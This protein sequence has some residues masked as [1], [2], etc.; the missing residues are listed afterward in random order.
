MDRRKEILQHIGTGKR[1]IEVAP[2]HNPLVP[3]GGD[4]EVVV[5][6]VFDRPTLL[7]RA[8]MDPAI[9]RASIPN[10][11]EVD[12]VGSACDIAELA[13][14][15]FGTD[16][17][18]DFVVSS[19]NVEHLPD[20]IRFLRGCE[21]LLAP[22]GILA[23]AVPDKRACFDFFRPH[24]GLGDLLQAFHERRERPTYAQTFGQLA[25][26][27]GLH[28][29]GTVTG[30]FSIN[31]DI[32][33]I[34]LQGDV[35]QA[36]AWWRERIDTDDTQYHD[37]HCWTFT[38][39]SL[40]L[41]LTEL[42]LLG[43]I[44]FEILEVTEPSGCEFFVHLR[45]RPVNSPAQQGLAERREWLLKR[46]VDEL[47]NSAGLETTATKHEGTVRRVA[48]PDPTYLRAMRGIRRRIRGRLGI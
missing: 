21:A 46:M 13:T 35:V 3:A 42:I 36:Y 5:L 27:A 43:L 15:R 11:G 7:T 22:G 41:I 30:A 29:Q 31:A 32:N 19:H 4:R 34:S 28:T 48:A 18:F 23:M 38:P 14:A 39:S 17:Q 24:S 2:W 8:E 45:K 12:L 25:Y 1:G 33:Q 10:I 44:D 20:P 9:D 26:H 16:V 37:S 6:D 47:G 40:Q